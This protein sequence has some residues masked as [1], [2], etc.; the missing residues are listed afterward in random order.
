MLKVLDI[1]TLEVEGLPVYTKP[2]I[3]G[4][5]VGY[6]ATLAAWVVELQGYYVDRV[7]SVYPLGKV[8]KGGYSGLLR[9]YLVKE[10][11]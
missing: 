10:I 11:V 8:T 7:K 3:F 6:E 9:M 1:V 4:N 5:T 2:S